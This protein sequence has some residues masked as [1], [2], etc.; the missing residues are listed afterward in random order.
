MGARLLYGL[1][2]IALEILVC[3]GRPDERDDDDN[4]CD[5]CDDEHAATA[6]VQRV[7]EEAGLLFHD[8]CLRLRLQLLAAGWDFDFHAVKYTT[9]GPILAIVIFCKFPLAVGATNMIQ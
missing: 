7:H 2:A 8:D 5:D 6:D 9:N 4:D 3:A 1:G